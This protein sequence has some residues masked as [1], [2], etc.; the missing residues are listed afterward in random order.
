MPAASRRTLLVLSALALWMSYAG[1]PD[2]LHAATIVVTA[3][4]DLEANDGVCTFREAATAANTD[5]ASGASPGECAA[6]SGPD[7]VSFALPPGSVIA[8]SILPVIFDQSVAIWGPGKDSLQIAQGGINRVLIFDGNASFNRSFA[9][10]GVT[11]SGGVAIT[12]YPGGGANLGVGGALLADSVGQQLTVADVRFHSN[13]ASQGGAALGLVQR[14]G[15]IAIIEDSSFESSSVNSGL[16]GGGGAILADVQGSVVV[17]RC[18]FT[19]NDASNPGTGTGDDGQGGAIWVPP[20]AVGTLEISESTFS[21]NGAAGNGGAISFGSPAAAGFEPIV[22]TTIQDSTFTLNAADTDLDAAGQSG[23]ALNTAASAALITVGN[24][25]FAGNL[26]H[27]TADFAPDLRG[28]PGDL[29]SSGY[30]FVGIRRGAGAVFAAGQPNANDDWVGTSGFPID[31]GLGPL[32]ENGGP[33]RSHH[34]VLAP[35]SPVIDKGSCSGA[36]SISDQRGWTDGAGGRIHDDGAVA[37]LDDG[38]DI[39]AIEAHLSPPSAILVDG[40]ETGDVRFWSGV[41]GWT[42]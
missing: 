6:G 42:S 15:G 16:A 23:G 34:P 37:D 11:L 4:A 38:C 20:L 41:V 17:R 10:F 21:A 25:I 9:L 18:L 24:S 22:A 36:L 5:T 30:N 19:G 1:G 7:D 27:G 12:D 3:T 32:A 29:A 40:F 14:T 33:T 39:G 31:P 8:L 13:N 35:A 26:D 28:D 2:K